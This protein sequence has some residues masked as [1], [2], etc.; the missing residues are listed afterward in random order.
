M[1]GKRRC[2]RCGALAWRTTL[3]LTDRGYVH[4]SSEACVRALDREAKLTSGR[5]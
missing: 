4:R 2:W 3:R 1:G 5:A